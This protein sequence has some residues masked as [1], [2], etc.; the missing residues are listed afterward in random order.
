M[1]FFT[2]H[3]FYLFFPLV[4]PKFKILSQAFV[5]RMNAD[6]QGYY[7]FIAFLVTSFDKY[8]NIDKDH[9]NEATLR[10]YLQTPN[11]AT[12]LKEDHMKV[13]D[14]IDFLPSEVYV[15][16]PLCDS[17]HT[18]GG[19]WW[20]NIG[21]PSIDANCTAQFSDVIRY[22]SEDFE[23]EWTRANDKTAYQS[24]I[25]SEEK[26]DKLLFALDNF[27]RLMLMLYMGEEILGLEWDKW[28]KT[29][30]GEPIEFFNGRITPQLLLV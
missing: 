13:V 19:K 5:D 22:L 2:N 3:F 24:R 28:G 10:H 9:L 1:V 11:L 17:Y 15:A 29:D 25:Q 23:H 4:F 12:R 27:R 6:E 20:P 26:P 30:N 14:N 8:P 21:L 7:Y 18:F 16:D